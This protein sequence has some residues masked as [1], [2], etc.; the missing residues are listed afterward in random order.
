VRGFTGDQPTSARGKLALAR[1]LLAGGDREAAR[2]LARDAWRS[3]ELTERVETEANELFRDLLTRDDHRAR[4]DRRIGAKDLA[5]AKRAAQRLGDDELAIVKACVAVRGKANK[6]LDALDAVATGARADLGYTLCRIQWMLAQNKIDDAARLMLAAS[7]ET[8]ALQDTDQWWRERRSLARKLLDQGKFQT[9]YDVIHPAAPPANEYYRADVHFMCGWIALRYLD[10]AKTAARHFA[11][12]DDG[13]TNPIVLARAN[14]WRGRV[15]ESL[16]QR[17]AM[18]VSYEA[19]ARYPTAYYGQLAR[20]KLGRHGIELRAPSPVLASADAPATDER[21]RAANML[22]EIGERDTVLY[23]VTDL[24]EESSDVTLL[25][26]L[27]ELTGRRNDA[28]AMLQ[29]GKPSLGRGMP[30]DHYAFPT[31]GIPPHRQIAPEIERSI[32]YSVAR[33]ESAF[34]QRDRSPANA[35]GLMQVTPEAGRDTAKRFKVDYDWDRMVSDPIYNTQMGAGELSAL[36][37]EYKGNPIMTFA[38]YNAGRGRVRDW[39]KAYGDPRDPKVDAVDWVERIPLSETRNYV[40][41]VIE[42]LAVYRVRFEDSTAVA[43]KAEER[44]VTQETNAAPIPAAEA[45]A[46]R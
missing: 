44:V 22:Y 29:I 13:A 23:F 7:P 18:R 8:M 11:H 2:R 25:E 37:S 46:G 21:V 10:D 35:V 1:V 30:L 20:A 41:R 31:I 39:I 15:A 24:G 45:A 28:R 26:A 3:D 9:A 43:A 42:N 17:E 40:Q 4:M 14:Y 19:A 36:L 12:I 5:A 33:T 6:A 27:G 38:G 16:G 34:D 32:I